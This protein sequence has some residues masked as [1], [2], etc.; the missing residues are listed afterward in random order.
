[1][2]EGDPGRRQE[3]EQYQDGLITQGEKY[4]K[5]VDAWAK[6]TDRIAEEM[7]KRISTVQIDQETGRQKPINSIYMMSHLVPVVRRPDAPASPPC[8]A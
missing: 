7:M 5:V 3:F 1:M 6:C 8:A 4:N 2:V